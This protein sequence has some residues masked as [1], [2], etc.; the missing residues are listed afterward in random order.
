[1]ALDRLIRP[2]CRALAARFVG[3]RQ[4]QTG[5]IQVYILYVGVATLCLMLL[6][7]PLIPLLKRL[8][9]R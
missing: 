3:I 5:R 1:V 7:V 2:F 9:T 4:W 6:V 8:L